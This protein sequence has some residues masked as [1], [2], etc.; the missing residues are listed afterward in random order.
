MG[1]FSDRSI[2]ALVVTGQN[3][4]K[5]EGGSD[6]GFGIQVTA[7]GTK[8]FFYQY[9]HQGKRRFLRLGIYPDTSLAEAR[10]KARAAYAL[11]NQGIDPQEEAQSKAQAARRLGTVRQMQEAYIAH[12]ESKGT[13][14]V[15]EIKRALDKDALPLIGDCPACDVAAEHIKQVLYRLISRDA[16]VGANRLRSYL[17]SLFTFGIQHD[18]D[19]RSVGATVLFG[20]NINPVDAVPRNAAAESVG[21]RVLSWEEIRIVWNA[22]TLHLP[23]RLAVRLLLATGGQRPGEV[24]RA[25]WSEFDLDARVWWLPA[26]RAKNK[27]DHGIPL[28]PLALSVLEEI[29]QVYPCVEY[30][31]PARNSPEGKKPWSASTLPQG[32]QEFCRASGM[33]PWVPKDIRRTVKTRMGEVGIPKLYRDMVQN[34][35]QNDVSTRHYDRYDYLPEKR[36]ALEK[37]CA[38]LEEEVKT[39]PPSPSPNPTPGPRP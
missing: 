11:V 5:H 13:R 36:A 25:H 26:A 31:F 27:H 10:K 14:S 17:H 30:I 9:T 1:A 23:Q 39:S 22:T 20:L 6:P 15:G 37:W 28:T 12:L 8:T 19:P 18:N 32:V 16:E 24:T 29:R 2:K 33:E 34:H 21:E 4:R 35:I 3:Y 7:Q 38:R